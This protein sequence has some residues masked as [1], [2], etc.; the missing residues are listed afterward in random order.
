MIHDS[1]FR[2]IPFPAFTRPFSIPFSS[3]S[4][5]CDNRA[6]DTGK[7]ETTATDVDIPDPHAP[8]KPLQQQLSE[9]QRDE[10]KT[11]LVSSFKQDPVAAAAIL[12]KSLDKTSRRSLLSA[13]EEKEPELSR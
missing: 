4:T 3:I 10:L 11:V 8:A 1:L 2:P 6:R 7:L 9:Q 5:S 13:L 12:S